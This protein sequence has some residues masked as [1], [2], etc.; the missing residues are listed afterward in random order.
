MFCPRTQV[1]EFFRAERTLAAQSGNH[2]RSWQNQFFS[3]LISERNS[4]A[5]E[6]VEPFYGVDQMT[7]KCITSHLTIGDNLAAG[8]NLH[9]DCFVDRA[10]LHL[11]ECGISQLVRCILIP[12]FLQVSW[13]QETPDHIAAIHGRPP[14]NRLDTSRWH[15]DLPGSFLRATA[16]LSGHKFIRDNSTAQA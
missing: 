7:V 11:L 16:L 10:I 12:S 6:L 5:T 9:F 14:V 8:T 2:Y 1:S 4:P 13:T 3:L 15:V